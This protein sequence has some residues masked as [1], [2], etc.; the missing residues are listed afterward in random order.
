MNTMDFSVSSLPWK[1]MYIILFLAFQ[2]VIYKEE[3]QVGKPRTAAK[4]SLFISA[5]RWGKPK[6][7]S[8]SSSRNTCFHIVI[9]VFM[10]HWYEVFVESSEIWYIFLKKWRRRK[11]LL[12]KCDNSSITMQFS[13]LKISWMKINGFQRSIYPLYLDSPTPKLIIHIVNCAENV[14]CSCENLLK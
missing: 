6:W 7:T 11:T 8:S 14:I 4:N 1:P 5:T 3:A 10:K 9:L 12:I 2:K 13:F